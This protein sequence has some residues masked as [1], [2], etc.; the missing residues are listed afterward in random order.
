MVQSNNKRLAKNT[1]I[2][3]GQMIFI[4]LINLYSIR[5][6]LEVLGIED[7][8]TYNVVGGVV[9]MFSFI[10]GSM[11]SGA[12]RF[13]AY[14]I[15]KKN[16]R[17][18]SNIFNMTNLVYWIMAIIVLILL[19]TIG[20][21]FINTR[22]VFGA[23]RI[24]AVNWIYQFSIFTFIVNII[25]IPYNALIVA[26]ER[27]SIYSLINIGDN[28]FKFIAILLLTVCSTD[29]L[30]AYGGLIFAFSIIIRLAFQVYCKYNFRECWYHFYWSQSLIK[31]LLSYSG[32]N[33]IG[34]IANI[35][36][37]EGLNILLNL[38]FG[39]FINAARGI[40][41]QISSVLNSFVTNLYF[42][43]RP[44][45][46]KYYASGDNKKMWNLVVESTKMSYYLLMLLSIPIC[47]EIKYVLHLWLGNYPKYA[48]IFL[49]LTLFV[50]LLEATSNQL[51]AVL[52]SANRIKK[53]QLTSSVILLLNIPVAYI[54]LR[55][56]E[57]PILP[58]VSSLAIS[59]VYVVVLVYITGKE[60]HQSMKYYAQEIVLLL[61]V[62]ILS[63]IFPFLIHHFLV[64]NFLRLFLVSC[65]SVISSCFFIWFV[66]MK[67]LERY[68]VT[69]FIIKKIVKF[70]SSRK[71]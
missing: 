34:A 24:I 25:S 49:I 8:G 23:G 13:F 18:L 30:I 26:Y 46:T 47:L 48:P 70:E 27:I 40:A 17:Q 44:Q 3:Y 55:V 54:L 2:L 63:F 9:T 20:L 43:S 66:G 35:A 1:M 29:K 50:F 32:Y 38:F 60:I 37:N 57:N 65:V 28:V 51:V 16:Y 33:M 39:P 53:V 22:M 41:V 12:Q 52:Q 7:Y 19:E 61:L 69:N 11:T 58:F 56:Q 42:S 4:T 21:W 59:I 15:G 45:I 5:L 6:L 68:S 36:R 71:H 31:S 14:E 10:S 62:T 67:R 64:E